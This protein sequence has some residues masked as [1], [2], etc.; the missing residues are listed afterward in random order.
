M[1]A[2]RILTRL[3]QAI[4]SAVQQALALPDHERQAFT[5]G[6][7]ILS[8]RHESQYSRLFRS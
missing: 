4:P 6:L 8:A 5:P 3:T 2:Q 1:P 7:A